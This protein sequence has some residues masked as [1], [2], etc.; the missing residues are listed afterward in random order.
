MRWSVDTDPSL[1]GGA[2]V[3]IP[4]Y[5]VEHWYWPLTMSWSIDTDPLLWVGALILTPHC[6]VEHWY[7]PL[8]MRWSIDTDPSLWGGALT[9]T[10]YYEV[11]H[12]YW[13]LN[14]RWSIDT[15]Q[16]AVLRVVTCAKIKVL[17]QCLHQNCE[18]I[19]QGNTTEFMSTFIALFFSHS[20]RSSLKSETLSIHLI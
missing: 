18:Y 5:E 4:H 6:E 2:L 11:E 15:D 8:T 19:I 12:W 17:T 20:P 13:P 1:W 10:P 9:L 7:W 14:M 3:L 16:V